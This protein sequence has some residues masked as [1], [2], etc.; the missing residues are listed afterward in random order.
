MNCQACVQECKE[1][2]YL[3]APRDPDHGHYYEEWMYDAE[4][5]HKRTAHVAPLVD[6]FY[7]CPVGIHE[8]V[9]AHPADAMRAAG[10]EPL[11]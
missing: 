2:G 11:L 5:E 9:E 3:C 7:R 6:G 10:Q 4:A 1:Q 8:P